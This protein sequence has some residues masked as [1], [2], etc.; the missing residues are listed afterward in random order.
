[1]AYIFE[2]AAILKVR[3][4]MIKWIKRIAVTLIILIV[5]F[6]LVASWF[7]KEA[8]GPKHKTVTIQLNRD[9]FLKC[10]EAYNAD[11]AA[12]FYDVDFTLINKGNDTTDLGSATFLVHNWKKNIRLYNVADWFILP[13]KDMSHSK[14]LIKNK[15]L[16]ITADTVLSPLEL[17]YDSVWSKIYDDIPAWVYSGSSKVDTII[18][19]KLLVTYEYRIGLYEPFKF[20]SQTIEY[21]IDTLNG[22]LKTRRAFERSERKNGS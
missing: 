4:L 16:D 12:V 11:M 20:F 6:L 22:R 18:G 9:S 19:R 5:V 15:R 1:M 14:L 7:L 3:C 13:V 17:R 8:F 2:L 21:E 10:R